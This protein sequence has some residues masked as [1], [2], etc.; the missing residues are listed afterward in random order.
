MTAETQV[1]LRKWLF[2]FAWPNG[3]VAVVLLMLVLFKQIT[4]IGQFLQTLWQALLYSNLTALFAMLI[5]GLMAKKFAWRRIP[6]IPMLLFCVLVL[7]PVACLVVQGLLSS[8]GVI[9]WRDYWPV[10]FSTMRICI[11]LAAIFGLGAF[12]HSSLSERLEHAE[13]RLREKE[14]AEERARKL[15]VEARLQSLE[16]R[17]RPH[18]LFNTLNSISALTAK[19]PARAEQMVGRLATLLRTSLDTSERPLIPLREELLMVQSYI[20]IEKARFGDRL[21]ADLDVSADLQDAKVPPMSVQSLVENA[22]KH[23]VGQKPEGGDIRI[24]AAVENGSLRV[25]VSD[26]GSGFDLAVV[27]LGHGLENLVERLNALF[28]EKARLN[29]ARRDGHCVVEMVLPL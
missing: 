23:G 21:S 28:G 22:V 7:V 16:A 15:I 20:D 24:T 1:P 9:P 5:V 27:P 14:L 10:Y 8:F 6:L 29:A 26:S 4:S 17:I 11:P 2:A 25:E 13:Q 19:D 3:A 12:V 18:F